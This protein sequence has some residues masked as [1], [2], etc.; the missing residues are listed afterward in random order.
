MERLGEALIRAFIPPETGWIVVLVIVGLSGWTIWSLRE[1]F[2]RLKREQREV[3]EAAKRKLS[4]SEALGDVCESLFQWA[5]YSELRDTLT[6]RAIRAVLAM[7]EARHPD[8]EAILT[9]MDY[10]EASRLNLAR[11][12]PNWL[13]L[14]GIGGT[15]IGLA[16]AV[17][18]LAPQIQ[19]AVGAV[20]PTAASASMA[21]ALEAMQHAFACSL[22]GIVSAILVSVA[23]RKIISQQQQVIASIQ[24]FILS[25]LSSRLLPKSEA[26][27][28]EEVQKTLEAGRRFLADIAKEIELTSSMMQ[29]AADNFNAVLTDTV[30]RMEGIG[31][32]LN[33]SASQIQQTLTEA[34]RSVEGSANKLNESTNSLIHSSEQLRQYHASLERAHTKLQ[35][36]YDRSTDNLKE[37]IRNQIDQIEQ[38][39]R[40]IERIE[41]G[42]LERL[43]GVSTDLRDTQTKFSESTK[44]V[45]EAVREVKQKIQASF[46]RLSSSL[47]DILGKYEKT[48]DQAERALREIVHTL[49]GFR[50]EYPSRAPIQPTTTTKPANEPA[51]S[52]S[53]TTDS[54]AT[55]SQIAV[56]TE[57]A[58]DHKEQHEPVPPSSQG[59]VNINHPKT[60]EKQ[61]FLKVIGSLVSRLFRRK[62]GG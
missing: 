39:R 49:N 13:L 35:E 15:V 53:S 28:I 25:E 34:T 48:S 14:V 46:D 27:Q 60:S 4:E 61:G 58:G 19:A 32:S 37:I 12:A 6:A 16:S 55:Y 42:M 21:K 59:V 24:E 9:M 47:E 44:E 8:L 11:S 54:T 50:T 51:P 33:T 22:W 52:K 45:F 17:V 2:K 30:Q 43:A 56:K 29:A 23:T 38:Y 18:P 5:T 31:A 41:R 36:L 1:E 3:L 40:E 20:E 10:S 57:T 62:E 7:R 26:V